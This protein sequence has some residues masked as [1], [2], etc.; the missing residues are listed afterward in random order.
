MNYELSDIEKIDVN[1]MLESDMAGTIL[2]LIEDWKEMNE[3]INELYKEMLEYGL[4]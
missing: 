2:N 3:E 1:R 4:R